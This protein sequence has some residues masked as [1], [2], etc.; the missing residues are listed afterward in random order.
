MANKSIIV[1]YRLW[2]VFPM[3]QY[4]P[5]HLGKLSKVVKQQIH[6]THIIKSEVIC[7]FFKLKDKN[8]ALMLQ[9]RLVGM[10]V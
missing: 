9:P 5:G 2:I 3:I 4:R 7:I 10:A 8:I 1:V 6:N